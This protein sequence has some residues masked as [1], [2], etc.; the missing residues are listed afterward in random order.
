MPVCLSPTFNLHSTEGATV[1][2]DATISF[3]GRGFLDSHRAIHLFYLPSILSRAGLTI[4]HGTHVRRAPAG[5]GPPND[6][7]PKF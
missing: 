2:Y 6:M 1:S 5:K 3:Q 7:Q 4:R